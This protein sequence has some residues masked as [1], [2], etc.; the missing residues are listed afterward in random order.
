[1]FFRPTCQLGIVHLV[2]LICRF[3]LSKRQ[4]AHD[5]HTGLCCKVCLICHFGLSECQRAYDCFC[6]QV[7]LVCCFG[8]SEC[9]QAH[10]FYI[11][12]LLQGTPRLSLWSIRAPASALLLRTNLCFG[13]YCS[14]FKICL[15][16]LIKHQHRDFSPEPSV[17]LVCSNSASLLPRLSEKAKAISSQ[18]PIPHSN[19]F[20]LFEATYQPPPPS[21]N[22]RVPAARAPSRPL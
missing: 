4:R 14:L 16:P 1:M 11:R 17:Q 8:L 22:S 2:C 13:N 12:L 15:Q 19:N 5:Y 10:N 6:C 3:G 7:C 9:Q 20:G 18:F 21:K